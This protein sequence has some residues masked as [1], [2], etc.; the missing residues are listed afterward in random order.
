MRFSNASQ[1]ATIESYNFTTALMKPLE[2]KSLN[3]NVSATGQASISPATLSAHAVT[4]SQLDA[5]A[6]S[7]VALTGDQDIDGIKSMITGLGSVVDAGLFLD[8]NSSSLDGMII[9]RNDSTG[10]LFNCLN[11]STGELFVLQNQSNGVGLKISSGNTGTNGTSL[12]LESVSGH[13]SSTIPLLV[14]ENGVTKASFSATGDLTVS[15]VISN[16]KIRLKNY[17]VSTL[18]AGTQGDTAYVTDALTPTYL[19]PVVGGGAIVTPVF[20][21]GTTWVAH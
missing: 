18:P 3:F 1:V 4:K 17:T 10:R 9:G 7:F 15:S 14:T 19:T 6:G 21:N 13:G 16:G 5:V 2:I 20:F 12:I 11:I 8:N